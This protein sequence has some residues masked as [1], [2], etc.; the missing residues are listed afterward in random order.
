M[1]KT[2]VAATEDQDGSA[3]LVHDAL[4]LVCDAT[5]SDDDLCGNAD[6]PPGRQRPNVSL[7]RLQSAHGPICGDV[8][9][10]RGRLV[11]DEDND[12]SRSGQAGESPSGDERPNAFLAPVDADDEWSTTFP[13][14]GTR[15]A[16]RDLRRLIDASGSDH[17]L[18][19]LSRSSRW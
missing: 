11:P 12:H 1:Q 16:A 2:T 18:T 14:L 3:S 4:Q 15:I 7:P 10:Q 6:E 8:W 9:A 17:V 5:L 19:S 13:R